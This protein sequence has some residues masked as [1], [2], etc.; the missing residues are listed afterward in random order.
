MIRK[1][2]LGLCLAAV[3][4]VSAI[5]PVQSQTPAPAKMTNGFKVDLVGPERIEA[6]E[7]G[8]FTVG[9][10]TAKRYAFTVIP[11]NV[12]FHV[13][14]NGQKAYL[15]GKSGAYTIVLVGIDGESLAIDTGTCA[16]GP[17]GPTPVPPGPT[18]VPPGPNPPTPV[19]PVVEGKRALLIVRESADTTPAMARLMTALRNPP[20]S[21]YLT[22]KAH[23]LSVIDDD[24]VD[25]NGQPTA[26]LA[27]WRPHFQGM[28]LPVLFVIDPATKT[29]IHK[30]SFTD[31]VPAAGIIDILKAH[32]G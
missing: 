19:P 14:S 27:S 3:F 18:P 5:V 29:L 22:S 23:T 8:V 25:E 16:I 32:G 24:A 21:T 26:V 4:T 11:S 9:D 6:G 2:I 1:S 13:D 15:G 17:P 28:T 30:Q 20:H 31:A 12:H 10:S 7:I